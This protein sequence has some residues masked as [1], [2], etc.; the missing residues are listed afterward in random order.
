MNA[1]SP[2]SAR[3]T[4]LFVPIVRNFDK[5][6]PVEDAHAFN[7]KI[8]EEDRRIVESNARR[9]YRWIPPRRCTY[10]RMRARSL[11]G[12]GSSAWARPVLLEPAPRFSTK[13]VD[14]L[15]IATVRQSFEPERIGS[16]TTVIDAVR[17]VL[18]RVNFRPRK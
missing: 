11:T 5:H 1:A 7:L 3:K 6:L 9:V 14:D 15:I 12:A 2:V 10:P 8:F 16:M 17:T 18:S 13:R 4:R